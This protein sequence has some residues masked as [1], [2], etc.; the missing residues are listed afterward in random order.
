[1]HVQFEF[2]KEDLVDASI[3]FLR[4]GKVRKSVIWKSS[5]Y[6]AL[7]VAVMVFLVLQKSP[8]IGLVFGLIA[9]AII[10]F[11]YP[12]WHQS[13]LENRLRQVANEIMTSPGPYICEV[14]PR[15]EGLWLR[16]MDTQIIYEWKS[17]E[18]LEE[19]ADSIDIF[20]RDG[21]GVIVRNRAF[22]SESDR[23]KF[24]EL[25]RSS[26]AESRS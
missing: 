10:V 24:V 2:T 9:A 3:R 21:G 7:A 23:A 26:L 11:L 5:V 16:Q 13:S 18:A 20:S 17:L 15:G 22:A 12:R 4:R 14:E 19:T 1:M 8:T 6:S 25:V